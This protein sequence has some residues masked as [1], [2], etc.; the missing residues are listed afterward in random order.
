VFCEPASAASVAGM[1]KK[2]AGGKSYAG[3]TVVCIITGS[4]LKDP[5]TAMQIEP[6]IHQVAADLTSVEREMGW[7]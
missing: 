1:L 4:G 5:E 6:K 3:Q 2:A 7:A